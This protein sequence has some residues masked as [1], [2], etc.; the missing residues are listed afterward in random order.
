M[1]NIS[2]KEHITQSKIAVAANKA[3][4]NKH[5]QLLSMLYSDPFHFI[6]ELLQ[7]AEDAIAR[8]KNA[9]E[10][11]FVKIVMNNTNIDFLHNG[12]PFDESDLMAVTTFASTT[13][14]GQP[15]INQIGKFGIGFRSV[16]GIT[17]NPE[18]HSGIHHYKIVDFEIPES[19]QP[20]T[21][22][23]FTTIIRLPFKKSLSMQFI[24]NLQQELLDLNPNF[25][26]FLKQIVHVEILAS[27][28][29]TILSV[30]EEQTNDNAIIKTICVDR[31][32]VRSENR[33]LLFQK[34]S[35][36]FNEVALALPLSHKGDFSVS[37]K[38]N[39]SVFFPTQLSIEHDVL[40]HGRFTTTPNRE[41]IPFS[42]VLT[43]ENE[44]LL[45]ELAVLTKSMLR[46][47]MRSGKLTSDF[48]ELF[49][50][51]ET[52]RDPVSATIRRALDAFVG[53]E[54]SI[55]GLSEKSFCVSDIC[56]AE[57]E[58]LME[59][60]RK[61][62]IA[63][64]Y[65][66][67]D[68]IAPQLLKVERFV[69]YLRKSHKLRLADIDSFAFHIAANPLFL[70]KKTIQFFPVLYQLFSSH[71]RLWD[72][73]HK[74]RYYNLRFAPLVPNQ[75]KRMVAA[76]LSDGQ[77]AIFLGKASNSINTVHPNLASDPSSLNFFRML[78]IP[79]IAHGL[80]DAEKLFQQFKHSTANSWWLKMYHLYAKGDETLR[81]RIVSKVGEIDCVP[82]AM[83]VSGDKQFCKPS[84]AYISDTFLKKYFTFTPALFVSE[85]L[86]QYFNANGVSASELSHFLEQM[87][88]KKS[89]KIFPTATTLNESERE[90]LRQE[91]EV[92][93]LVKE[94]ILDYSID[95]LDSFLQHPS[96]GSSV[97]LWKMLGDI[98]EEFRDAQYIYESYVRTEIAL[99]TPYF[100]TLLKNLN[101]IFNSNMQLA[102][103]NG[104]NFDELHKSYSEVFPASMW[105]SE[106][107]GM[108][109][110]G[111]STDE[112]KML[113][114]LRQ[115]GI[116]SK[117]LT[118][119]VANPQSEINFVGYLE[120]DL[121]KVESKSM[122]ATAL[123]DAN[124]IAQ[125]LGGLF[126]TGKNWYQ[127]LFGNKTELLRNHLMKSVFA[128]S[129]TIQA[130]VEAPGL[131]CLYDNQVAM[132]YVFAAVSPDNGEAVLV[133]PEWRVLW[134]QRPERKDVSLFVYNMTDPICVEVKPSQ[135]ANFLFSNMLVVFNSVNA[136]DNE[137]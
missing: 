62:D 80:S 33:F 65:H 120:S 24:E 119:L 133:C 109:G 27:S 14:K 110:S 1:K 12:D 96:L 122:Q 93:P 53:S 39:V 136:N 31:H 118:E 26:L 30:S 48:F 107:L 103:P 56:L 15:E 21:H 128:G 76:F 94:T 52:M 130:V 49:S 75:Q 32:G 71:H 68:F 59:L 108:I 113:A 20:E 29:S 123:P 43:P 135:I 42:A 79:E 73:Q 86:F 116:G 63:I 28:G 89:L 40:V 58:L 106:K 2:L 114:L 11:G 84:K 44:K 69:N 7:N 5:G 25:L 95:G 51:N 105:F 8:R 115:R 64:I 70:Q 100:L 41:N 35:G 46:S 19:V 101:W 23:G 85:K 67:F 45:E 97:A 60:V 61:K 3:K 9:N 72:L 78:G 57:D 54:K 91:Q 47:L 38:R 77:P 125:S 16:Y 111:I 131:V 87:G 117:T 102:C 17:D 66:R 132:Q 124:L 112:K 22:V 99:F 50:W 13:K 4:G 129:K 137:F 98:T 90:L 82:V 10:P 88:V 126:P 92:F 18:I 134:Q 34:R 104:F 74:G 127:F 121:S 36:K 83:N 6:E 81:L 55:L 37:G